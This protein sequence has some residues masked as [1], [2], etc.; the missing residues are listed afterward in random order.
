MKKLLFLGAMIVATI[1]VIKAD[2]AS[3]F[4]S[5]RAQ[6]QITQIVPAEKSAKSEKCTS[7]CSSSLALS[8][9]AASQLTRIVTA[10]PN[11]RD[12]AHVTSTLS[13]RS[14]AQL[15]ERQARQFEVA[16]LK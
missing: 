3:A 4:L 11:D 13:P 6:S 16:P 15:D 10:A 14:Q 2:N 9:R 7:C 12:L 1:N 8:P 5:P